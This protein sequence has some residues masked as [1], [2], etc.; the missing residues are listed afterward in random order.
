MS[1]GI[2][3]STDPPAVGLVG[4]G[5]YNF[6]TCANGPGEQ[7]IRVI[8]H[9]DQSHGASA[10]RLRTEI[11]VFRRFIGDPEFGAANGQLR[12]DWPSSL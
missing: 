11:E 5:C 9:E 10:E 7:R 8:D 12:D 3:H 2:Y 6:R 1:I 4:H